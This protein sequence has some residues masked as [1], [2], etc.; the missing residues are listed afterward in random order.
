MSVT[1]PLSTRQ[2]RALA[3]KRKLP[4]PKYYNAALKTSLE[5]SEDFEAFLILSGDAQNKAASEWVSKAADLALDCSDR[6]GVLN[7]WVSSEIEDVTATLQEVNEEIAAFNEFRDA[8]KA[9]QF[10]SVVEVQMLLTDLQAQ[11]AE[12]F[13]SQRRFQ[14]RLVMLMKLQDLLLSNGV[15]TGQLRQ[16]TSWIG[17]LSAY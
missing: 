4:R 2:Q 7:E 17:P 1:V 15:T 12:L 10:G 13:F 9:Q 16:T 11:A 14:H 8:F 3:A 6:D 5:I